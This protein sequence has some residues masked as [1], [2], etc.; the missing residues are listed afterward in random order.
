MALTSPNSDEVTS[1]NVLS[2]DISINVSGIRIM[3]IY[4]AHNYPTYWIPPWE[5][6][7]ILEVKS[8]LYKQFG[9]KESTVSEDDF[10]H[11]LHM[12]YGV[13]GGGTLGRIDEF[14]SLFVL[15]GLGGTK[16]EAEKQFGIA[17]WWNGH[18]ERYR[19]V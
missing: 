12:M 9:G 19:S 4:S 3:D 13:W 11:F 16:A 10:T 5:L 8:S 18:F 2:S 7:E 17:C 15:R 14:F 6:E 1:I